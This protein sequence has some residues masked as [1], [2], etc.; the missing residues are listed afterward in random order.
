MIL[1]FTKVCKKWSRIL[2]DNTNN[3]L[4]NLYTDRQLPY[5]FDRYIMNNPRRIVPTKIEYFL[6]HSNFKINLVYWLYGSIQYNLEAHRHITRLSTIE[7]FHLKYGYHEYTNNKSSY[8]YTILE[9]DDRLLLRLVERQ[10]PHSQILYSLPNFNKQIHRYD[11]YTNY[12]KPKEI[13]H[14][15]SILGI[16]DVIYYINMRNNTNQFEED[17]KDFII[18]SIQNKLRF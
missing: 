6:R 14:A 17:S 2:S 18:K 1:V 16:D 15:I 4:G 9:V 3:L 10:P 12:D 11:E 8:N 13:Y 5:E 7:R